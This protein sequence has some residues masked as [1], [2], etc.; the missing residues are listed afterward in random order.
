[1][2]FE[3]DA[4]LNIKGLDLNGGTVIG[5]SAQFSFDALPPG[6]TFGFSSSLSSDLSNLALTYTLSNS[7][8]AKIFPEV[9]FFSFLDGDIA[10]F[11]IREIFETLTPQELLEISL[12]DFAEAS[13][14]LG[15]GASDSDPDSWEIDEPEFLFGDIFNNLL[16]GA[17]D[18]SNAIP[19]SF[20]ED[21]SLALGFNLGDLNPFE[22]ATIDVFLSESGNSIGNFFLTQR[23][24]NP[25]SFTSITMSGQSSVKQ[26]PIPPIPEPPTWLLLTA[27]LAALKLSWQL[28]MDS[29]NPTL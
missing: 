24:L 5:T 18:N 7:T 22:T 25:N 26:N 19:I 23:D 29:T 14:I 1:M 27:G 21:A 3:L 28:K 4:F 20:P 16:L 11:D 17:L 9:T 8:T 13:G 15:S 6:L 10:D 2:V 12:N